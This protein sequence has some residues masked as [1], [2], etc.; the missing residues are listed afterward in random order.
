MAWWVKI[1]IG[2]VFEIIKY[3][4][5]Q[6]SCP[7]KVKELQSLLKQQRKGDENAKTQIKSRIIEL[8][9]ISKEDIDASP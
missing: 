2:L 3:F 8:F 1:S 4:I 5:R 7:E 6:N 9:D